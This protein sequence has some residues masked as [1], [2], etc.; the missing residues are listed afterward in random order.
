MTR[1][2]LFSLVFLCLFLGITQVQ[3]Q[4]RFSRIQLEIGAGAF[5]S[6][7]EW[8]GASLPLTAE[9]KTQKGI[10]D[11]AMRYQKS[12]GGFGID[13]PR[14]SL[15]PNHRTVFSTLAPD[16]PDDLNRLKYFESLQLMGDVHINFEYFKPVLGVGFC[17]NR[18]RSYK[19]K[20][21]NATLP[22][23]IYLVNP[24]VF[25]GWMIRMGHKV[26]RMRFYFEYHHNNQEG[27][28]PM[29]YLGTAVNFG[30]T[31]RS[32]KEVR[33]Y[34]PEFVEQRF[35]NLIFRIEFNTGL[36]ASLNAEKNSS[37]LFFGADLQFRL[38]KEHFLGFG[39][40]FITRYSGY[41]RGTVTYIDGTDLL[42]TNATDQTTFVSVYY[43][44]NYELNISK[45]FYFGAGPGLYT[46]PGELRPLPEDT[47]RLILPYEFETSRK[48]GV[49]V[50]AGLRSG[51]LS[52]TI[53]IHFTT[54]DMPVLLEYKL[55]IGLNFHK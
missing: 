55:G 40:A 43:L 24:P 36:L 45:G 12:V 48:L 37:S 28:R 53:R 41:D 32:E 6:S 54:G 26:D 51:L 7:N 4:K 33:F 27:L 1:T 11:F 17:L 31:E 44:Y 23:D 9:L 15:F 16:T 2:L 42:V 29:L 35:E 10:V 5:A 19:L 21:F 50:L 49:N 18:F 38:K 47:R 3:A 46:I 39:A 8:L 34:K 14:T 30:L 22:T 52:N 25:Y 13:N 20:V